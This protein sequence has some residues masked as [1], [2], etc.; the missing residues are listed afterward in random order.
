MALG[1]ILVSY[2]GT[3][4]ADAMLRLACGTAGSGRRLIALY[5]TR[6]PA[7]LP[8]EPLP[9]WID[10]EGQGAL[11]RA[12]AI[13]REYG[14]EV[15]S[16]LMRAR[17]TVEAIVGVARE[18]EADAIFLP[19]GSW[20]RPWRRLHAICTARAVLR[21]AA[22]PVLLGAWA[23]PGHERTPQRPGREGSE[24]ASTFAAAGRAL[25]GPHGKDRQSRR[26]EAT[27]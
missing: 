11:D 5:V 4:P 2:D 18:G 1:T 14:V 23:I 24:P 16:W 22:C 17:H 9:A 7:S 12:E 10:E 21:R 3:A 19:L 6:I 20:R 26:T 15:E 13:A 8:L 27:W 25:A